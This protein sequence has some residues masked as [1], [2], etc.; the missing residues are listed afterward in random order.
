MNYV[1]QL[2]ETL[3]IKFKT[4]DR[5]ATTSDLEKRSVHSTMIFFCLLR[6]DIH[7][8]INTICERFLKP[9]SL[10]KLLRSYVTLHTNYWYS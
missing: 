10:K 8:R 6:K 3:K 2:V 5:V 4:K 7:R 1:N 9:Q